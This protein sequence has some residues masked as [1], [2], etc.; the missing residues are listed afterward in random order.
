MKDR[1][2]GLNLGSKGGKSEGRRRVMGSFKGG[3]RGRGE[4]VI[5]LAGI[6]WGGGDDTQDRESGVRYLF[7]APFP[8]SG[9]SVL[10]S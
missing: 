2:T 8:K 1:G 10:T 4:G 5:G 9:V 6:G 7:F 3:G